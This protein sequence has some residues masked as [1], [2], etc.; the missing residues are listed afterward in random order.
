VE[1]HYYSVPYWFVQHEVR[2]K[3]TEKLIEVFD[4]GQRIATHERSRIGYRHST[5]AEHMPPVPDH[6]NVRGAQYY[7]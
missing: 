3:I 5:L 7:H 1:R 2:L 4:D 6:D